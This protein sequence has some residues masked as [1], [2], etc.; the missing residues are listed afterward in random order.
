MN[1]TDARLPGVSVVIPARN[2]ASTIGAAL[3]S[4]YAQTYR[5]RVE[6]VV[7][8]G[9]GDDRT[10]AVVRD[11]YPLVLVVP[12]PCGITPTGLNLGIQAATADIIVRCDAHATL[13]P[14]Y[15]DRAVATLLRTGAA[16]VGG[17]QVP[18]SDTWFGRAVGLGLTSPLGSGNSR[19][20]V[21]GAEGP[22]EHVYLGVFRRE[23]LEAVG[24][25]DPALVRNQDYELSWRL[26]ESGRTVWFDPA[27]GARYC[28][29]RNL[30]QLFTQ[31]FDYG[32]W[33]S[34]MLL[35]SPRALRPRQLAAPYLVFSLV[36]SLLLGAGFPSLLALV[37]PL[38][39]LLL[40][41]VG[42]LAVGVR[43]RDGA[44]LL[45]PMVL[46]TMHLGWGLGFFLPAR[47]GRRT[48]SPRPRGTA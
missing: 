32:R 43:R 11:R 2:A 33:K 41:A 13:P 23:A 16:N 14:D 9:S 1:S 37:A 42:S 17:R 36:F 21:G 30:G 46:A 7:A 38:G 35:R 6:V 39:Y 5:G 45:L 27:L 24:G 8:D 18:V 4:I 26:R 48:A 3:D 19:Y 12:N 34:A 44:A 25:F 22:A 28:P 40:L 10:A 15:I 20:K 31:Y 29:R 47:P